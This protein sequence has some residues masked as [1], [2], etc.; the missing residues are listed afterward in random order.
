[1]GEENMGHIGYYRYTTITKVAQIGQD[2]IKYG[3]FMLLKPLIYL[4]DH[5]LGRALL[6]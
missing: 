5:I 2:Q 3:D 4:L 1:M 6:F